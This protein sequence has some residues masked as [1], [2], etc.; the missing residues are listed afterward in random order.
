MHRSNEYHKERRLKD[1]EHYKKIDKRKYEKSKEKRISYEQKK[2]REN[3]ENYMFIQV[4]SRAKRLGIPFELDVG[5][6]IIPEVCPILG[7]P[8]FIGDNKLCA[9]SPSLDRVDNSLGYIK[10]NVCVISFKAN[11][12]KSDLSI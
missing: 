4:K 8:L 1:P 9:N 5:D 6:I 10:G 11:R 3:P 12:Y 2:R 7:I